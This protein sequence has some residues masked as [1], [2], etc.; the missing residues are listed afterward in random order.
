MQLEDR[1]TKIEQ[2]MDSL[3]SDM[4]EV[5]AD[6]RE[7]I[8]SLKGNSIQAGFVQEIRHEIKNLEEEI[9]KMKQTRLRPEQVKEL[10]RIIT[11]FQGWKMTAGMVAF[12]A[13]LIISFVLILKQI[14]GN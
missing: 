12:I 2:K 9:G 11:F 14:T 1:M 3:S 4:A 10:D 5:K 8:T 6:L 7:L 13:Q